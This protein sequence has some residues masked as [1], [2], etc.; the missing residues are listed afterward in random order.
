MDNFIL[1]IEIV[2]E[3]VKERGEA[4]VALPLP[5]SVLNDNF[6]HLLFED[7]QILLKL[8]LSLI[9]GSK[10]PETIEDIIQLINNTRVLM[11]EV[12]GVALVLEVCSCRSIPAWST[13]PYGLDRT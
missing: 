10:R 13:G 12:D 5:D 2:Q 8:D 4:V 11:M 9:S 6:L 3:G 7:L 1:V